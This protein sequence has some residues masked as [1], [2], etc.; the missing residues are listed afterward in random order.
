MN[1]Q[2]A[3][4]SF[5]FK[6]K[7]A[8]AFFKCLIT[9]IAFFLS[10]NTESA[11]S[12]DIS[13]NDELMFL[14]AER[15]TII[16]ASKQEENISKT[17][18]TS[19]VI[20]QDDIRQIGARNLLD[21]L[22]LVPGIGITQS[23]VGV[24]EIEVRGVKSLASE[25]VLFM[26]NGHP[27]DHNLQNAGST[28]AY[29]DLPVDNIKR[30]EVVRGPGSALYGANAFLA[31]VNIITMTAKDLNGF[32]ASTG[33]G[34]FDTQQYRAAWGKQFSNSAEAAVNFNYATTNGINTPIPQDIL[35]TSGLAPGNSQLQEGRYDAEWNLGYKDFKLD[36]RFINKPIG[37]FAGVAYALSDQTK[38]NFEDYFLRLSREFK[39]NDKFSI[40]GQVYHDS[41]SFDN[42][43]QVLPDYFIHNALVDNRN[44]GEIQANYK[45]TDKQNLISGFSYSEDIQGNLIAQEG[46]NLY[47][48]VNTPLFGKDRTRSRWGIYAQDVWDPF[49]NLRLTIGGRYDNYNDFGGTFN[50]RL[51][52]NWEFIKNYSLKSS[53]G[54][55]YRAPSFGEMDLRNNPV[56]AG[57]PNL[58]PEQAQTF[59]AGVIG[60]PTTN[61]MAQAIYYHT[62][63]SQII[64][65]IPG[66]VT[67]SEYANDGHILSEG[68]EIESRYD[69]GGDLQGSFI[70]SNVVYQQTIQES[71]Q[72]ADVPQTRTNLMANWAYDRQWSVY[73]HMLFKD[74]T[75]RMYGDSRHNVPAYALFD[76][77]LLGKQFINKHV[78]ISFTIYNL[79]DKIVYDPSPFTQ[80][81]ITDYQQAGRAYFGHI[82]LRY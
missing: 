35:G 81:Q 64:S 26:L 36:G 59:E 70:A 78:D 33:F 55:A 72:V 58:K 3:Q 25:K 23:M 17:V 13:I 56:L 49:D 45:L 82:N 60:H 21:V 53:Y 2:P 34:S 73:G 79:L 16:T 41:F 76:L 7:S 18:A 69:F 22:R 75:Q 52:F 66:T 65:S 46:S 50:P 67:Q 29:D 14:A 42:T 57:N 10:N 37:T 20:T 24:R 48:M 6:S 15:Q 74:S 62:N 30:V 31:V 5:I 43:F 80:A 4:T 63:I 38:Q 39:I 40:N 54:T 47:D 27:L 32:Q 19:S 44:G 68:V 9:G 8:T 12:Q 51:G 11:E 71:F 77:S 61:L 1:K 28:W